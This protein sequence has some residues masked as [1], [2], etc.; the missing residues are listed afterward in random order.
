MHVSINIFVLLNANITVFRSVPLRVSD[1]TP[2]T[3]IS[4]L[5][6]QINDQSLE[7]QLTKYVG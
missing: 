4:T 2:E 6:H 1:D 5:T 7:N 3:L